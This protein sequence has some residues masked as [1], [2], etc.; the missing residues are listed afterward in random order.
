MKYQIPEIHLS[1]KNEKEE[2]KYNK[3]N[4]SIHAHPTFVNDGHRDLHFWPV[5]SLQDQ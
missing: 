5:T 4:Q 2:K 1:E 3:A